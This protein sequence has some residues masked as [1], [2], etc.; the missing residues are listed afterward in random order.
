MSSSQ[1]CRTKYTESTEENGVNYSIH[2]LPYFSIKNGT[3]ITRYYKL[4]ENLSVD[5]ASTA[6]GAHAIPDTGL[7]LNL[8]IISP[9]RGETII[10]Y[11]LQPISFKPSGAELTVWDVNV[12]KIEGLK[13]DTSYKLKFVGETTE[14]GNYTL[15]YTNSSKTIIPISL[16]YLALTKIILEREYPYH[17]MLSLGAASII[18]GVGLNLWVFKNTRRQRLKRKSK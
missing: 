9:D 3:S 7:P 11:W 6:P 10:T 1:I 12:P 8:T 16:H 2:V 5:F 13:Q 14:E 4:G 17:Y 18:V 15:I